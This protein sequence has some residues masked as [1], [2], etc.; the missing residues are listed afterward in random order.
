MQ[1]WLISAKVPF[2]DHRYVSL[3]YV[4]AVAN[5]AEAIEAVRRRIICRSDERIEAIRPATEDELRGLRE[6]AV[7]NLN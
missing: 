4:A 6:G 7:R 1:G 3:M 5:A 2:N